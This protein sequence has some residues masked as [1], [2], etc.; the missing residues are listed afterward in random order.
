M[1]NRDGAALLDTRLGTISTLN[2]EGAYVWQALE[3]G[4]SVETIA[5]CMARDSGE[6]ITVLEQD[7]R[8]FITALRKQGL[9][10]VNTETDNGNTSERS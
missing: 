4:E 3:R 7:V 8:D 6:E 10:P 5:A 9:W 1:A 2:P